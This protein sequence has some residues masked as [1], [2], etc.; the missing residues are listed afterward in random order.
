MDF[1]LSKAWN[2]VKLWRRRSA[3]SPN[4]HSP[5]P[6][7]WDLQGTPGSAKKNVYEG[8]HPPAL[9]LDGAEGHRSQRDANGRAES[10]FG[11]G[12]L[13]RR[14]CAGSFPQPAGYTAG[15]ERG[16]PRPCSPGQQTRRGLATGQ[17]KPGPCGLKE[18]VG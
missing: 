11:V 10:S 3:A 15:V 13:R 6:W 14:A 2:A 8:K 9:G 12:P 5:P 17:K 16:Q 7:S 4:V 18:E 1:T